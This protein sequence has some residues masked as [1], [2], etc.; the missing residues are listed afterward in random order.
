MAKKQGGNHNENLKPVRTKEEAR[1]RGRNGGIAS[2]K[3][4][5]RKK[6][7]KQCAQRVLE[8]DIP[9]GVKESLTKLTGEIDSEDDTLFTAAVAVMAKEALSGNVRAF[10]E[11]RELV[12]GLDEAVIEDER[13][14]D[15]LSKSLR[16]LGESL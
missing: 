15:E 8:S 1:K 5:R 16:E 12:E 13:D 6:S 4:R 2:G 3:A 11:L 7:L 10:R 14:E 9:K